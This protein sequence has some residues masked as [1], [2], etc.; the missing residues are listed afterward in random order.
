MGNFSAKYNV[1]STWIVLLQSKL[2][3]T[4]LHYTSSVLRFRLSSRVFYL[5]SFFFIRIFLSLFSNVIFRILCNN[6]FLYFF[7]LLFYYI[8]RCNEHVLAYDGIEATRIFVVILCLSQTA[9][10]LCRIIRK[11]CIIS[12]WTARQSEEENSKLQKC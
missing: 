11:N 6:F 4:K 7:A 12:N 10:K 2:L 8:I 3:F 9:T 1:L 5:F